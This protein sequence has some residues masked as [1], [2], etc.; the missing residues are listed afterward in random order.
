MSTTR[1]TKTEAA[2]RQLCTAIGLYFGAGDPVSTWTLGA[3]SYNVL[4]DLKRARYSKPMMLKDQ[5]PSTLSGAMRRNLVNSI[6]RVENFFKHADRD[7]GETLEF[8]PYG[9]IELLLTDAALAYL[10]LTGRETP[11]MAL[12]RMWFL[13]QATIEHDGGEDFDAWLESVRPTSGERP[14]DYRGRMWP[15]AKRLAGMGAGKDGGGQ[16]TRSEEYVPP[17]D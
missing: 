4:R 6:Q 1:V 17:R 9:R 12:M 13:S 8:C 11:E 7:S 15:E 10:E 2:R 3:A 14:A 16:E 5:L